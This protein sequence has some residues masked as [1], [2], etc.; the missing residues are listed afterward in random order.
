MS[1]LCKDINEDSRSQMRPWLCLDP[2]ILFFGTS[3]SSTLQLLWNLCF[4]LKLADNGSSTCKMA[5]FCCEA[6][7]EKRLGG[8]PAETAF[9]LTRQ[10]LHERFLLL[11]LSNYSE[12]LDTSRGISSCTLLRDAVHGTSTAVNLPDPRV[13]P[14]FEVLQDWNA[15]MLFRNVRKMFHKTSP[16]KELFWPCAWTASDC[17]YQSGSPRLLW[18]WHGHPPIFQVPYYKGV[19]LKIAL[20]LSDKW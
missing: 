10:P 11:P 5:L 6:S 7:Q 20:G 15:A 18:Q 13:L 3:S 1:L 16:S 2:A 12:N 9:P 17:Y 14:L 4:A 19:P 8:F